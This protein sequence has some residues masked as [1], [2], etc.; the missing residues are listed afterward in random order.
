MLSYTDVR[1]YVFTAV[2][3][4]LS[5]AVPMVCHRFA[6]AGPTFLPMHIFVLMAGLTFGWRG[7]LTVGLLTPLA[8]H[9]VSGMPLGP[10]LPQT[11]VEITAYGLIAGVLREI[12]KLRLVWSLAGAM[13][14]GRLL[15]LL[16]VWSVHLIG[17]EGYYSPLGPAESPFLMLWSVVRQGWPG[18]IIQFLAIPVMILVLERTV[19]RK[20]RGQRAFQ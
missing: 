17:G 5:V 3:V 9:A 8:S 20:V 11:I 2:F 13:V 10:V 12:F 1:S 7:G 4:L 16:A 14:G 18:M 19:W 15:L 6:L